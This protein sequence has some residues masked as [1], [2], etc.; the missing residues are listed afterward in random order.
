MVLVAVVIVAIAAGVTGAVY[1]VRKVEAE[2]KQAKADVTAALTGIGDKVRQIADGL[3]KVKLASATELAKLADS[4]GE[5]K[6]VTTAEVLKL[7]EAIAV[8]KAQLPKQ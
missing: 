2:T 3:D 5:L 4:V 8:I 7:H 6:T 1:L